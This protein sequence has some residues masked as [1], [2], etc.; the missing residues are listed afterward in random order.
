MA[1][2]QN[3]AFVLGI[4]ALMEARVLPPANMSLQET[5]NGFCFICLKAYTDGHTAGHQDGGTFTPVPHDSHEQ[6]EW[7]ANESR[8]R[9]IEEI[10]EEIGSM[11]WRIE[12][13]AFDAILQKLQD[14][15]KK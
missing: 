2:K 5:G 4:N 10:E 11:E 13:H 8:R 14:L 7:I 3:V 6:M 15:K 12:D 9:T 1:G